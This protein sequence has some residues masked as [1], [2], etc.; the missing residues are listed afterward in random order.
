MKGTWREGS[1]VGDPDGHVEKALET[2]ISF[3][4][5][6]VWGTWREGSLVGDPDGHVEKALET[7]ISFQGG[8]VWGTWRRA[9]LPGT[10]I[11]GCRCSI[12]L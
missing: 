2:D 10:L 9:R 11:A 7:D 8:P 4:G 5:G 12:S 1:L 6:P 3:Q